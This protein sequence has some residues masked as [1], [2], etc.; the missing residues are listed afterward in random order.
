MAQH[1]KNDHKA[2]AIIELAEKELARK[3][4]IVERT[5]GAEL[6]LDPKTFREKMSKA[7][8]EGRTW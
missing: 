6:F 1:Q 5:Q 3:T 8:K 7:I 2:H 4:G